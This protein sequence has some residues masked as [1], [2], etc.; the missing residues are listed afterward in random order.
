MRKITNQLMT[1]SL[2]KGSTNDISY[3]VIAF[4]NYIIKPSESLKKIETFTYEDEPTR[5]NEIPL[6][7]KVTTILK[8]EAEISSICFKRSS[9][10]NEKKKYLKIRKAFTTNLEP[11]AIN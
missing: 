11:L 1:N 6:N 5:E 10:K 8:D 3:I 2:F 7:A 4:K 9:S